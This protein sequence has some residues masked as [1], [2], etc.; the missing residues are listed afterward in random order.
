MGLLAS[1]EIARVS[2][3]SG[4]GSVLL[5]FRYGIITLFD[6]VFQ[7]LPLC[8]IPGLPA[9][10]PHLNESKWFR[11]FPLRSPL[12]RESR[13]ISFPSGTEMFHFPEF[14]SKKICILFFDDMTLLMPGFPIQTSSDQGMFCSSPRLFAAYHVFHRLPTPRH[15]PDALV[16]LFTRKKT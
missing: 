15:P 5:H 2:R 1:H 14:A 9:L 4:T 6:P 16:N 12:L 7:L 13:L 11:L 3:Y 8:Q 10:Q